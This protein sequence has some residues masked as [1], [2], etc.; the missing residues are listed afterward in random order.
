M[1]ERKTKSSRRKWPA[2]IATILLLSATASLVV[3]SLGHLTHGWDSLYSHHFTPVFKNHKQVKQKT[4]Q[5]NNFYD[6]KSIKMRIAPVTAL[7]ENDLPLSVTTRT[8][9]L[10]TP[11]AKHS[12][13]QNSGKY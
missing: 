7:K 2:F 4:I 9:L 5:E 3:S 11:N 12:R 8:R 1:E 13:G 6:A 10:E